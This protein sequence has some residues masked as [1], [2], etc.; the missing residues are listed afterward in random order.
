MIIQ[1]ITV[2]GT[3]LYKLSYKANITM[4]NEHNV[5]STKNP[6]K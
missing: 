1:S 2:N 3:H 6:Q 5:S 4:S